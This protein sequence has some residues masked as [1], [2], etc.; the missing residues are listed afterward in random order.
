M[1][2]ETRQDNKCAQAPQNYRTR[3]FPERVGKADRLDP[4]GI[5]RRGAGHGPA[6]P[7]A[8][9]KAKMEARREPAPADFL[10]WQI[11]RHVAAPRDAH[12]RPQKYR[13]EQESSRRDSS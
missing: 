13:P 7:S 6:H 10:P 12:T 8:R 3:L 2:S 9:A 4:F 5:R 11:A 1:R